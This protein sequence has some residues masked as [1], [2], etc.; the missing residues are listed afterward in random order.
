MNNDSDYDEDAEQEKN[1]IYNELDIIKYYES[2]LNNLQGIKSEILNMIEI[3]NVELKIIDFRDKIYNIYLDVVKSHLDIN[4]PLDILNT[5][6]RYLSAK[7]VNFVFFNTE[8]GINL[9]YIE[10]IY[11]TFNK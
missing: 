8:Y 7:F 1:I 6:D 4:C 10:R 2:N 3:F 11:N 9:D 5:D